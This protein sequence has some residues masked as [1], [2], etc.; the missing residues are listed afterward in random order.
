MGF[1]VLPR[2]EFIMRKVRE[3]EKKIIIKILDQIFEFIMLR[4]LKSLKSEVVLPISQSFYVIIFN[5]CIVCNVSRIL[6]I[7]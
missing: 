5:K 2:K 3:V 7:F 6:H 1:W 4:T